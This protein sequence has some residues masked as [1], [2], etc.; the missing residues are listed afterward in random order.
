LHNNIACRGLFATHYHELTH[1]AETLPHLACHTMRVKEWK[2]KVAF[3]HEVKSGTADRSYGIHVARLAGLPTPVLKRAELILKTLE[4]EKNNPANSLT[5]NV[6]PLFSYNDDEAEEAET[7]EEESLLEEK[8]NS[9][10][11]DS[12]TP[13][14]ALQALYDLKTLAS[15]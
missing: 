8:L 14:E 3:L 9:I 5:A 15:E 4:E 13:R 10:D 1:L 6:L 12:L 2:G 7:P 11:P